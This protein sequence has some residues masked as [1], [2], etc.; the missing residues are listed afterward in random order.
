MLKQLL[1]SQSKLSQAELNDLQRATHFDKKELQQWYKGTQA[2]FH[3][4]IYLE[5][6]PDSIKP[7]TT[8]P[9]NSIHDF[10]FNTPQVSQKTSPTAA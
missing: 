1:R 10:K 2:L 5:H 6:H 7:T 8:E 9:R 4:N 3:P